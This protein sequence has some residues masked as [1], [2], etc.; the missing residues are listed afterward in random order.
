M[1]NLFSNYIGSF[2]NHFCSTVG[3]FCSPL[4]AT[5]ELTFLTHSI[6]IGLFAI[7]S[8]KL[9]RGALTAF[10]AVCWVLGNLFVIKEATIFNLEVI[11]ADA[12]AVGA[13]LSITL[14]KQ[15]YGQKAAQNGIW[16]GFYMALFFMITSIIHLNYIPNAH[17]TT[18]P[19]F[20]AL[21]SGMPRIIISS[22]IVASIAQFLNLYLFN[23]F[24]KLFGDRLFGLNAFLSLTLSQI[25]DTTLFT[26]FAL[27]GAVYSIGSIILFSSTVKMIAI[28]ISIPSVILAQQFITRHEDL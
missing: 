11:T 4:F 5:N 15:Y 22:F 23:W 13:S 6:I 20:V 21:L 24:S 16:I 18:H 19:H 27:S 1:I 26:L 28:G 12:F 9:G 25:L 7:F 3:Y 14:L 8:V 2:F 17:D 10:M